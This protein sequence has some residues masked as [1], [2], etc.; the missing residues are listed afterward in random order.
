MGKRLLLFVFLVANYL[1]ADVPVPRV[2]CRFAAIDEDGNSYLDEIVSC[3]IMPGVGITGNFDPLEIDLT[4]DPNRFLIGVYW[5]GEP[6]SG[7]II[8]IDNILNAPS[9][10]SLFGINTLYYPTESGVISFRYECL[11]VF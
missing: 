9:N 6:V 11:R 3:P 7:M 10:V 1:A 5:E 4:V 2:D 8:P